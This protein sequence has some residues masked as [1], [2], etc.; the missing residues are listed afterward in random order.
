MLGGLGVDSF[1]E[2][3]RDA[4]HED[5]CNELNGQEPGR[6][7][8]G[9]DFIEREFER[10]HVRMRRSLLG[11]LGGHILPIHFASPRSARILRG[12]STHSWLYWSESLNPTRSRRR[13]APQR[14]TCSLLF[15]SLVTRSAL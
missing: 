11:P 10:R 13:G 6:T 8:T 1:L 4:R 2:K 5:L 9:V 3:Q 15:P 14:G 7:S 12:F